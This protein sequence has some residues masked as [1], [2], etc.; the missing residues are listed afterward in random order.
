MGAFDDPCAQ[1]PIKPRERAIEHRPEDC[2]GPV[3]L[4]K[5]CT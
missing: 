4:G 3:P 5:E 1:N 2:D